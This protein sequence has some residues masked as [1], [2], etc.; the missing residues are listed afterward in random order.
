MATFVSR[1]ARHTLV[2]EPAGIRQDPDGRT[3]AVPGKRIEFQDGRFETAEKAEIQF[4]RKHRDFG[5]FIF[6][7]KPEAKPD[8]QAN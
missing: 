1:F 5:V 7:E 2:M 4:I 3:M 6:E 8:P